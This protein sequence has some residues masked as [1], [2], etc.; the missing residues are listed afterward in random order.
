ME[1]PG[2]FNRIITLALRAALVGT[3]LGAGWLIYKQL[4]PEPGANLPESSNQTSLQLVLRPSPDMGG[5]MLD[6][7]IEIYPVDIVAVRQEVFHR[8]SR[9][10]QTFR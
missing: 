6:I 1:S 7:P 5:A 2:V 3:L 8:T 9:G 10:R 4:P